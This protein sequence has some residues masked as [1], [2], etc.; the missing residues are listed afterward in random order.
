MHQFTILDNKVLTP[1]DASVNFFLP[2][3]EI[4][5]F[6]AEVARESLCEMNPDVEGF[7]LISEGLAVELEKGNVM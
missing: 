1:Q 7:A 3:K 5:R 4:G 2:E 6:R